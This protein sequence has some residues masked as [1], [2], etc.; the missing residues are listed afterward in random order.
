[1][2]KKNKTSLV[3]GIVVIILLV[4]FVSYGLRNSFSNESFKVNT[5]LLK[6]NIITEGELTTDVTI[7][8]QKEV[9][10]IFNLYFSGL[11]GIASI[12]KSQFSLEAREKKPIKIYFRDINNE[13]QVY[14]GYLIIET[15]EMTKKVP[16]VLTVEDINPFFAV[17][18]KPLSKYEDVSPGGKI[19]M[20]IKLFNLKSED[21][22]S[23]NVNYV[24][25]NFGGEVLVS[26]DESLVVEKSVSVSKILDTPKNMEEG[27][28]VFITTVNYN[29]KSIASYF[30]GITK[31]GKTGFSLGNLEYFALI[32]LVFVVGMFWLIFRF[33]EARDKLILQLQNQQK[34]ELKHN[35]NIIREY[36]KELKKIENIS[37]R[38]IKLERLEKQKERILDRIKSKHERQK[39]EIK[40]DIELKK[41]QVERKENGDFKRLRNKYEKEKEE[42]IKLKEKEKRKELVKKLERKYENQKKRIQQSKE[43]EKEKKKSEI[44]NRMVNKLKEWQSQGYQMSELKSNIKDVAHDKIINQIEKW[45]KEGYV[46]K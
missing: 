13:A 7:T 5:I 40:R 3:I 25:K 37:E 44:K 6:L 41:I 29:G 19:G 46:L 28:Y 11:E 43:K 23:V 36:R 42:I 45:K 10:Q 33:F 2:I 34:F 20:D 32:V 31:D 9:S 26:E 39:A 21:S 24:V 27:D 4:A 8:N 14:A 18:Q 30:F 22:Q 38:R 17:I 12:N 15:S 1:M 35:L 16:V